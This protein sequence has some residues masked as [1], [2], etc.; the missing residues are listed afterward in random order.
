MNASARSL[1]ASPAPMV[2]VTFQISASTLAQID[3]LCEACKP[4][5]INRDK[6]LRIMVETGIL[7]WEHAEAQA[8]RAESA[9]DTKN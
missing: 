5:E 7:Y 1:D 2:E 4:L 6:L 3:A 8:P 9:D